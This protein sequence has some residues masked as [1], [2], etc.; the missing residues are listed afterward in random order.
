[1]GKSSTKGKRIAKNTLMMYIRM[2][3][4]MSISL[5]TSRIVLNALGVENFGIYNVVGGIVVLFTFINAAMMAATQRFVNYELGQN[6]PIGLSEVFK[7]A[8]IIH[9]CMALMIV[10]AGCTIGKYFVE[11]KFQIPSESRDD[12]SYVLYFSILACALQVLTLPF[13]ADIVAH[14]R[15]NVYAWVSI[16]ESLS[17]LSIALLIQ[18]SANN[19]LVLYAGL[20][21]ALQLIIS[22]INIGYCRMHFQEVR[23]RLYIYKYRLKEMGKF[24]VWCLIGCTAGAFA[25]QGINVLL[26]MFFNPVVNAAR[27]IAVQVQ[28]AI[29]TFGSNINTAMTPQ[30]TQSYASRDYQ[31]FFNILYRGSKY[32]FFMMALVAIPIMLKTEYILQLWLGEVPEYTVSFLRWIVCATLIDSIS[33]P[34]MRASDASGRIRVYHSVVGGILL[35]IL[36]VSYVILRI[37]HDPVSVFIVYFAIQVLAWGAR[38]GILHNTIKLSI[39]HYIKEVMLRVGAIFVIA[40]GTGYYLVRLLP[41]NFGG[42]VVSIMFTTSI[43][44]LLIWEIGLDAFERELLLSKGKLYLKKLK[45][46]SR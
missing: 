8:Y 9:I 6:N 28:S 13:S 21:A 39:R 43:I 15:I 45:A 46:S 41:D 11:Y 33:F 25:N 42:L 1:M 10:I 12:A 38:L 18:L 31:F 20:L 4:T 3:I 19:R 14:E 26:G 36:P 5:Y 2:F 34:L 22:C 32:V 35:L 37:T 7:T 23:G 16:F 44:G 17:R 30:I 40:F 29:T 24:A 27:G